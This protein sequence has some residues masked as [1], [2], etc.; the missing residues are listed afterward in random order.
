MTMHYQEADP[1]LVGSGELYLGRVDDPENAT[2]AM[3]GTALK[4]IGAI[5]AGA[6]FTYSNE[7]Q[8]INSANRGLIMRFV[9][10]QKVEFNC[11]IM[12]W[13]FG[14]MELLCPG[15]VDGTTDKKTLKIGAAKKLPVNYLRFVH[16]KNDGSGD[17][18]I[19]IFKA[20]PEGG[21]ELTFDQENPLSVDYKFVALA[22]DSG[23]LC[24]IIETFE[25]E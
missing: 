13:V 21:F 19:N 25:I 23:N 8:E 10:N 11:G 7:V 24:E 16:S 14:N 3:I 1:I 9:T 6:T 20:T 17:L 12:T 18:I 5:E 2:E 22:T 4:N 15:T